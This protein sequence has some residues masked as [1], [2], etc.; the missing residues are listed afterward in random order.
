MT[1]Q[2]N[3]REKNENLVFRMKNKLVLV[4][5]KHVRISSM[6][7]AMSG[8]RVEDVLEGTERR[9]ELECCGLASSQ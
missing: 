3:I 7:D 1:K 8:G 2:S 4:F 9:H 6:V 5:P